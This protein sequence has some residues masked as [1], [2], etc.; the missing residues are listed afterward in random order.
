ME[1]W[2]LPRFLNVDRG[3][4]QSPSDHDGPARIH[5]NFDR[6]AIRG[7]LLP[8]RIT[9]AAL[10]FRRERDLSVQI[11]SDKLQQPV[12]LAEKENGFG[13][14]LAWRCRCSVLRL[15]SGAYI[16]PPLFGTLCIDASVPLLSNSQRPGTDDLHLGNE[17]L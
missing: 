14:D 9:S 2:E 6:C 12:F 8:P 11:P 7:P 3:G 5:R 17:R 1:T 4:D 13:C 16:P 10:Q 15:Q